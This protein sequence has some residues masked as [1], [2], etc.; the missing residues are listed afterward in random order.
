MSHRIFILA[1]ALALAGPAIAQPVAPA[2]IPFTEGMKYL[3]GSGE[4]AAISVQ[5]WRALTDFTSRQVRQRPR[6]SAVLAAGAT[7]AAPSFV[8]CGRKPFAAVFDVDET[9]LLNLGFEYDTAIG[10]PWQD[11]RWNQWEKTG[12]GHAAAVPGAAEGLRRLRAMGVKVI[13]NTN[14]VVANAATNQ[15]T[16]EAAGLGPARHGDTLYLQGDDATGKNKDGR[17]AMIAARYCV[18][19]MGGDQLGDFSDLFA[20]AS[21]PARRAAT[22]AGPI[23]AKWGAGWFVLPNPVYGAGLKGSIDDVFPPAAHWPAVPSQEK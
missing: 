3:Y 21:V 2:P 15:A 6:D 22:L 14:R 23:A 1:A 16:I 8:P 9:V 18:I 12:A 17:R 13:F 11:E 19:A 10:T 7:L 5:A 4:G 20:I